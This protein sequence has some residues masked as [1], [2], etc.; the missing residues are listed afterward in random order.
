MSP[1]GAAARGAVLAGLVAALASAGGRESAP[2]EYSNRHVIAA[3]DSAAVAAE[4]DQPGRRAL[5]GQ[6][7]SGTFDNIK[8]NPSLREVTFAPVEA[9]FFRFTALRDVEQSGWANVAEITVLPT[10][11]R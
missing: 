1:V 10:T 6:V 11:G 3:E 2:I 7:A 5:D 9:R 8:Y 4:K